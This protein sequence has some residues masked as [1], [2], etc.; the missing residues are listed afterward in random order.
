MTNI[1]YSRCNSLVPEK[2]PAK[3]IHYKVNLSKQDMIVQGN[4]LELYDS[5]EN[6]MIILI[7]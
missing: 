5:G 4:H 6:D 2:Q 3:K 7:C 1:D